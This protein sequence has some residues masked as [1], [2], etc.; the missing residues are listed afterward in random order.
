MEIFNKKR[1]TVFIWCVLACC[2]VIF[3]IRCH[4]SDFFHFWVSTLKERVETQQARTHHINKVRRFLLNIST[5]NYL[6]GYLV[7][8]PIQ[9]LIIRRHIVL[10][11]WFTKRAW[12]AC[13]SISKTATITTIISG[14]MTS[15]RPYWVYQAN[16]LGIEL[17]FYAN[18]FFCFIKPT[19]PLVTGVTLYLACLIT[20]SN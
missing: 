16:P 7:E 14:H 3:P 6:H 15:R 18:T 1:L 9:T 13:D 4:F 17:Y 20:Y 2:V 10:L 5:F 8:N 19:W 11:V 12:A